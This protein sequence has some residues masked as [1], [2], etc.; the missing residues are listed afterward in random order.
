MQDIDNDV[1]ITVIADGAAFGAQM[2]KVYQLVLRKP[3]I[4]LYL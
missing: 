1:Y 4:Q 2:E 3:G